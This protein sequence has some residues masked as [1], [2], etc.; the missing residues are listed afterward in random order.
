[1]KTLQLIIIPLAFALFF[2]SCATQNIVMAPKDNE[3]NKKT[4]DTVFKYEP[5]Y[6][7]TL[8]K[9]DKVSISVWDNDDLSVGSI[10][11]IY[12]SN[13]VY[14]KWLM[15]D[16][17]GNVT[18]P[19]IGEINLLGLTV[20]QAKEKLTLE[21]K[22]WVINPII[23]VKVL[24]KE[25]NILGELKNPGKIQLEKDNNTLLDLIGK[26]GDFDFYA[27][28]K[29]I[30]II[31]MVN[32]KPVTDVVDLTKMDNYLL[33][34]IQIHPGDVIYVPSR[35]GKHWDRRAGSTIIP[36]ASLISTVVLV[37]GFVRK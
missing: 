6:Q 20:V 15:L 18:V 1:M 8:Q 30:E 9:D 7:Y 11:G 33:A 29:G 12:N 19:K 35:G 31:R 34:N 23:E 28:K 32:D 10:Y 22:K 3:K 14:G 24:N 36:L 13:E 21:F 4:E 5:N 17:N 16:V 25:V 26:A 2:S 27:N 37:F